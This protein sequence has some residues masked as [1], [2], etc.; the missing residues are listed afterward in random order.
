M[1]TQEQTVRDAW[2][3]LYK[4]A[5]ARA[6]RVELCEALNERS[7]ALLVAEE[8]ARHLAG[9]PGTSERVELLLTE[10]RASRSAIRHA[11]QFLEDPTFRGDGHLGICIARCKLALA[12]EPTGLTEP[13]AGTLP[14]DEKE[15][16]REDRVMQEAREAIQARWEAF[17]GAELVIILAALQGAESAAAAELAGQVAHEWST[18]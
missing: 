16:L 18:R 6:F 2:E 13:I 15:G 3:S 1:T 4:A 17:T 11:L 10:A 9:L 14:A 8:A 7:R 12:M 5:M